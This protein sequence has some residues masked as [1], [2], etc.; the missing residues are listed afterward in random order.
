MT[1]VLRASVGSLN[2]VMADTSACRWERSLRGRIVC[3]AV[4]VDRAKLSP[5]RPYPKLYARA[6]HARIIPQSAS[7]KTSPPW[8]QTCTCLARAL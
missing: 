4:G 7:S 5:N 3:Y 8:L 2:S 1:C 6:S